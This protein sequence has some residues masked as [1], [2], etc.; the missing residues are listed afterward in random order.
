VSGWGYTRFEE[1]EKEE[2][3]RLRRGKASPWRKEQ[4]RK[5]PGPKELGLPECQPA[6]STLR[7]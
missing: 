7:F 1:E 5:P 2:F 3:S 6:A 4:P